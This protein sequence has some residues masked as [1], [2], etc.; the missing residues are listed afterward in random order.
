[1][2]GGFERI[3]LILSKYGLDG[4][5]PKSNTWAKSYELM[6][7]LVC[8]SEIP[9]SSLSTEG[10]HFVSFSTTSHSQGVALNL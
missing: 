7:S 10:A 5:I 1:M 3:E 8:I 4:F 9:T 2:V 6:K